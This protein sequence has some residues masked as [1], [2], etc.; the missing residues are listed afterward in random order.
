MNYQDKT[1]GKERTSALSSALNC[2]CLE[3]IFQFQQILILILLA[4]LGSV[5]T[6][7]LDSQNVKDF[8]GEFLYN[9]L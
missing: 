8:I 9:K 1:E 5:N 4:S 6:K 2:F 7:S 3:G